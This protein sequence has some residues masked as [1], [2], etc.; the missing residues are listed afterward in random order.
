[1][2][3]LQDAHVQPEGY[4]TT[5]NLRL[6]LRLFNRLRGRKCYFNYDL[7]NLRTENDELES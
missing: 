3:S 6:V 1:M 4:Q 2:A 5:H 7:N